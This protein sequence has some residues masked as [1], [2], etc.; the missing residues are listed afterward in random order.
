MKEAQL[1]ALNYRGK[2]FET[3]SVCLLITQFVI[4]P[5]NTNF[6]NG[7]QNYL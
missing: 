2:A 7:T 1:C 6:R 3:V 5:A 4:F